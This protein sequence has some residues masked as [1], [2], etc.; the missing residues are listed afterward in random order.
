MTKRSR[1]LAY[2]F[3][4][5]LVVVGL[6]TGLIFGGTLGQV[7]ALVLISIGAVLVVSLIFLEV[8]LSED[9][10]RAREAAEKGPRPPRPR[11]RLRR[12]RGQSRRLK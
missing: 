11:S 9:R 10:A 5:L 4:A 7:L 6:V 3:A 8:G 12:M 1:I 2:G